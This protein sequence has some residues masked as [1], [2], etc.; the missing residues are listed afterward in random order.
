[1]GFNDKWRKWIHEFLRKRIVTIL[2]NGSPTKEIKMG[3]GLRQRDPLFPLLFLM[4]AEGINLMMETSVHRILFDGYEFGNSD[5]EVS[6][7]QYA[8]GTI[9]IGKRIWKNVWTIKST[10]KMFELVLGLRN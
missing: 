2:V 10:L 1:M 9:M 5:V 7:I 8:N 4:V 6:H 3:R